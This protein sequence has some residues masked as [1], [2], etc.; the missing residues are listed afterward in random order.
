[1]IE[2]LL[3]ALILI[4]ILCIV[5]YV[6]IALITQ[7]GAAVPPIVGTIIWAVIAIVCLVI[8]ARGLGVAL[9]GL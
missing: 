3:G 1:M 2:G 4:G 5:A 9:P 8:L 6:V 7:A